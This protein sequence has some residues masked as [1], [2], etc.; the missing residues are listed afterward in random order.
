MPLRSGSRRHLTLAIP[1]PK[2]RRKSKL[3][4]Y[5]DKIGILP[6]REIAEAGDGSGGAP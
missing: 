5:K 4:P 2:Y 1:K 3:D 6:D